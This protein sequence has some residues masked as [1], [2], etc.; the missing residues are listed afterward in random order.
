MSWDDQGLVILSCETITKRAEVTTKKVHRHL[1]SSPSSG[2]SLQVN[3]YIHF[4]T[5]SDF[6]CDLARVSFKKVT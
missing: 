5:S 6:S 4:T 2:L 1:K 3:W